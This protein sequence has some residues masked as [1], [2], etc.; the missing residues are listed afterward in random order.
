MDLKTQIAIAFLPAL[1]LALGSTWIILRRY[2][3]FGV[4]ET[5]SIRKTHVGEIPRTG[6]LP[7]FV[8]LA[9]V[10]VIASF[11]LDDFLTEWWPVAV[12]CSLIFLLGFIDDLK[13]LGAKVKLLG[14]VGVA[15][16]AYGLGLS[17]DEFSNPFGSGTFDL[18]AVSVLVTVFWFVAIT[19]V[20]NLIDGM[21]GL[22]S[23]LGTF[24][25][26]TLGAIGVSSGQSGVAII[27]FGMAGALL[28]FLRFNFPPARIFL[29][30]GGAYLLGFFIASVST[31][32][33]NKGS[34]AAALLV[35][36]VALGLPILDTAFA[37]LRRGIRGLPLFRADAEHIHHRL[38]LLG[39]SKN[40][41]LITLYA[42]CG[43]LSLV[44]LSIFWSKGLTLPIAGGALFLLAVV[45]AKF[46]GYVGRWSE[47]RGQFENALRRR[48]DVQ[49][50]MLHGNLLEVE[51]ERIED[52]EEYWQAFDLAISKIGL[53]RSPADDLQPIQIEMGRAEP[54]VVYVPRDSELSKAS[55]SKALAEC[56]ASAYNLAL[57]KWGESPKTRPLE[58]L[59][60]S[61]ATGTTDSS[62][63]ESAPGNSY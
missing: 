15:L 13:P 25:C 56:I 54:W 52:G 63:T 7:I 58:N 6:G 41:A 50:A 43:A 3:S 46:L 55:D 16:I 38:L 32:S 39:L 22:A 53:S 40:T 29:G 61:P 4:D 26:L 11:L 57:L 33:S 35:V 20:V 21:D 60:P 44:G 23:G 9:A 19:N 10:F 5:K 8:A 37:I 36:M 1:M 49:Y 34:V 28:G 17:I 31:L 27:S 12:C 2:S 62:V 18:T 51:V 24:L 59:D 48:K 30:D 14:Q 45:A 42:V 47:L